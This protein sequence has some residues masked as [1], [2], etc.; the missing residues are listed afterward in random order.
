MK[1]SRGNDV[2]LGSTAPSSA[3][4]PFTGSRS[5]GPPDYPRALLPGESGDSSGQLSVPALTAQAPALL[6]AATPWQV[7]PLVD[8]LLDLNGTTING[9]TD[10]L[11]INYQEWDPV[12][13]R[14][15][16]ARADAGHNVSHTNEWKRAERYHPGFAE[17][18]AGCLNDAV[19][20][21]KAYVASTAEVHAD[22]LKLNAPSVLLRGKAGIP[23]MDA[24]A[25]YSFITTLRHGHPTHVFELCGQE[26]QEIACNAL[27]V[28][29][30]ELMCCEAPTY[31]ME[32]APLLL[33]RAQL[34][35][36]LVPAGGASIWKPGDI[37]AMPPG[38][39]HAT[40]P[41]AGTSERAV[42]FFTLVL[43]NTPHD[44][45]YDPLHQTFPFDVW[46]KLVTHN[47]FPDYH[48]KH[49]GRLIDSY[50]E[51]SS[52]PAW[53]P[54]NLTRRLVDTAP[55]CNTAAARAFVKHVEAIMAVRAKAEK[56]ERELRM[57]ADSGK[58]E[59]RRVHW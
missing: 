10:E 44:K 34:E 12:L 14:H 15:A 8:A 27:G 22:S 56:A 25:E 23:H 26:N 11:Y 36:R 46:A 13:Q 28:T 17:Q 4:V 20:R 41:Q 37:A 31:F 48:S 3:M 39:L 42:L 19:D 57:K 35:S 47:V 40:P 33:S 30:D 9:G 51:W 1:R 43:P 55:V 7:Q 5:D 2:V 58:W 52:H 21:A 53:V 59:M 38:W 32:H 18:L 50:L 54:V 24:M 16:L 29:V 49:L 6:G 45:L